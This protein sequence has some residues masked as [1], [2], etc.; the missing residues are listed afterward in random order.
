MTRSALPTTEVL[1]HLLQRCACG[2][3]DA[4]EELYERT[5]ASFF[6]FFSALAADRACAEAMTVSYFC[7]LWRTAGTYDPASPVT[8]WLISAC[9]R[10]ARDPHGS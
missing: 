6:T 8:P 7:T 3:T 9:L 2:E 10:A 5:G 1:A 4:L